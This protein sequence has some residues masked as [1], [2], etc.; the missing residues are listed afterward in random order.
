MTEDTLARGAERLFAERFGGRPDGV[1]LAPGRVNLIGEHIDYVGGRVAPFALPYGTAVALRLRDDDVLRCTST[2]QPGSWSG[3]VGNVGPGTPPDWP[4]YAVGV[5]WAMA[6]HRTVDRFPGADIAVHSSLP[7]GAGLSSSAALETAVALGSAELLGA[8]T[9]DAGRVRLADACIAAENV[10]AGASTGGMDQS[11]AL[12]ARA[13]HVLLLDCADWTVEHI[14]FDPAAAD[15]DVVVVNTNAPH[16]LADGQYGARRARVE[17]V[18]AA[19][20]QR[21][22]RED[23]VDAVLRRAAGGDAALTP[24]LRHILTEIRRVTAVVDALRAG[25]VGDIGEALSASHRSLRDDYAVSSPELDSAVDAA[26]DGGALGARMIGGGFGGS[27][28]AVVP[29]AARPAMEDRISAAAR[30]RGL[31]EP[32]FLTGAPAGAAHRVG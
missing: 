17:R 20:G 30:R 24:L 2:G 5:L 14:P 18:A 16:R 23:D 29:A 13:G 8:P 9:D 3:R 26:L 1:W 15:L 4:A 31:P 11:V 22:L 12:R 21:A 27:A 25:R 32:Q 19:L 6:E 7:Q 28:I 10:V